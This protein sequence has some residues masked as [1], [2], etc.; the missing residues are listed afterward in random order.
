VTVADLVRTVCT[1]DIRKQHKTIAL[2]AE[3]TWPIFQVATFQLG[4]Y[5]R[6]RN[7]AVAA[8]RFP[9]TLKDEGKFVP[10]LN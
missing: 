4:L 5:R 6:Y 10:V 1:A 8:S 7:I 3:I 9:A 2:T